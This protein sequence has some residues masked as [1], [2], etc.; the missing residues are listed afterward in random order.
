VD[1][2]EREERNTASQLQKKQNEL[3]A[4][5]ELL[6]VANQTNKENQI[7]LENANQT[8]TGLEKK[9]TELGAEVATWKKYT[10]IAIG[11][12]FV[13]LILLLIKSILK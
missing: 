5:K 6:T 10:K 7:R 1:I 2:K 8:I 11:T 4:Q 3:L 12:L 13:I 9:E